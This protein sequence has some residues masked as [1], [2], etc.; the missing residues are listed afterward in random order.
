MCTNGGGKQGSWVAVDFLCGS[1]G[2]RG[3]LRLLL[4]EAVCRLLQG[5]DPLEWY[6]GAVQV[7]GI[8]IVSSPTSLCKSERG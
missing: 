7:V 6:Y 2:G 4:P 1:M 8:L 3:S 5:H